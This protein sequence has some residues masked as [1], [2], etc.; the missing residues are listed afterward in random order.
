[1]KLCIATIFSLNTC[2]RAQRL[3]E[4]AGHYCKVVRLDPKLTKYGCAYGV[5]FY[6]EDEQSVMKILKKSKIRVN[7]IIDGGVGQNI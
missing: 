2:I 4:S 1:M 3:L 5:E 6:R 7:Q